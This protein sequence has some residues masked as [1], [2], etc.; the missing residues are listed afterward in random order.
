MLPSDIDALPIS[1]IFF[2]PA[3][4]PINL[5]FTSSIKG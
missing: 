1:E 3:S 2:P 5:T 4:I